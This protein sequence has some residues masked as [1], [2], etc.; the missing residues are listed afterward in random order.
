VIALSDGETIAFSWMN[1]GY[2]PAIP[3]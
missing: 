2:E 1:S 3:N